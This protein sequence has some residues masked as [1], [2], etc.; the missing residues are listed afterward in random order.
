MYMWLKLYILLIMSVVGISDV[1]SETVSRKEAE[2]IANTFFNA[3]C[4]DVISVPDLVYNGRNLT[5]GRL[6][7]PFY[8]F[9]AA[10]NGFVVVSAENKAFPILAYD[11]NNKFDIN[12]LDTGSI[13]LLKKYAREIEIVRYDSRVPADAIFAW[14]N[15]EN[16]IE[17]L[18]RNDF[19]GRYFRNNAIE[20]PDLSD[21]GEKP[22]QEEKDWGDEPAF[23][24]L[25]QI[26]EGANASDLTASRKIDNGFIQESNSIKCLGGGHYEVVMSE[27]IAMY[28]IYNLQGSK[29]DAFKTD[30]IN[31]I[32][33]K[34]DAMPNGFY[35]LLV[36]AESG[37]SYGFKLLK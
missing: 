13:S 5:T 31:V 14:S 29:V 28:C 35:F 20:F 12:G 23:S 33:I 32:Y 9:N 21:P 1:L 34:L 30:G 17:N 6:F 11:R 27:D 10:D 18:L 37:R 4:K 16:D 26:I 25:N 3:V 19:H 8:V 2:H 22:L 7:P 24:F 36:T 15:I